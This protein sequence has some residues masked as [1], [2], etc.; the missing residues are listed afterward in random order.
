MKNCESSLRNKIPEY[1]YDELPVQEKIEMKKH[2]KACPACAKEL[3]QTEQVLKKVSQVTRPGLTGSLFYSIKEKMAKA[4]SRSVVFWNVPL[5]IGMVLL[6]M[7]SF[8]SYNNNISLIK[9]T[10]LD[11]AYLISTAFELDSKDLNNFDL[12]ML[13]DELFLEENLLAFGS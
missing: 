9:E 10:E 7:I 3:A 4:G 5:A 11:D 6:F 8:V 1:Y 2:L 12:D 13:A